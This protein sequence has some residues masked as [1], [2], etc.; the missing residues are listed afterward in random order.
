[1]PP[2]TVRH[3]HRPPTGA[4]RVRFWVGVDGGGTTTRLRLSDAQGRRL[5]EGRAGPSALGQGAHQ[6]WQHVGEAL[7]EAARDAGLE[8]AP[9]WA[10][11]A[12]GLGLSGAA[13]APLAQAFLVAR[14]AELAIALDT[15]GRAGVLGAHG[16]RP[17]ALVVAGTGSVAEALDADGGW[18]CVG[19]WG[20]LNG[21]EGSGAWLGKAAMRHAQRARDGR[22]RPGA[23][24]RAVWALAGDAPEALLAWSLAAQQQ[25][26]ASLAPL[27]FEHEA[28]DPVAA[29]LLAQAADELAA[30][31]LAVDPS[32]ALPLAMSGSIAD[33]L[34]PRLPSRL[35]AR[36]VSPQG[37]AMDGALR[38]VQHLLLNE[39]R[40]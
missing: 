4:A 19:G 3:H 21:D 13:S 36:C 28:D 18:R 22:D 12:L 15:D 9:D 23:L 10:D 20:W 39:A 6:A 8:R 17:G 34:A 27:V 30:L 16:A 29:A 35:R 5:G 7:H 32:A 26:F 24:A 14:P 33:R 37:D 2:W 11:C 40:A 25:R 31:A 38:M 1:M